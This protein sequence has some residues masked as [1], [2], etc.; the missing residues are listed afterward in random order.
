MVNESTDS[1]PTKE[2]FE[3]AR[4]YN[5]AYIEKL[6]DE[7]TDITMVGNESKHE[8]LKT[9][10]ETIQELQSD[11]KNIQEWE[12]AF[13]H[14]RQHIINVYTEADMTTGEVPHSLV[15]YKN[16]RVLVF[17]ELNCPAGQEGIATYILNKLFDNLKSNLSNRNV[18]AALPSSSKEKP[19]QRVYFK[20]IDRLYFIK[21]PELWILQSSDKIGAGNHLKMLPSTTTGIESF[22][23]IKSGISDTSIK[24][25]ICNI[26]KF[27]DFFPDLIP[28]TAL[29]YYSKNFDPTLS[30]KILTAQEHF[31]RFRTTMRYDIAE[32][33]MTPED[34]IAFICKINGLESIQEAGISTQE[35]LIRIKDLYESEI[36]KYTRNAETKKAWQDIEQLFV[37]KLQKSKMHLNENI[38]TFSRQEQSNLNALNASEHLTTIK[39]EDTLYTA[40][41]KNLN[42]LSGNTFTFM[43]EREKRQLGKG[44]LHDF[45]AELALKDAEKVAYNIQMVDLFF[46][47]MEDREKEVNVN[48]LSIYIKLLKTIKN[49]TTAILHNIED[50]EKVMGIIKE[51]KESRNKYS[52]QVE[53]IDN[54]HVYY[55]ISQRCS[56]IGFRIKYNAFSQ[57]TKYIIEH[58][59]KDNKRSHVLLATLEDINTSMKGEQNYMEKK[60]DNIDNIS[61]LEYKTKFFTKEELQDNK[62]IVCGKRDARLYNLCSFLKIKYLLGETQDANEGA[63]STFQTSNIKYNVE[64]GNAVFTSNAPIVP[65]GKR[66]KSSE[67]TSSISV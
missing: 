12:K 29:C 10:I 34:Q 1:M 21:N 53:Y 17:N 39:R 35:L 56:N 8:D 43:V 51:L 57:N 3:E 62:I 13:P 11:Y 67:N 26:E 64:E 27:N 60:T 22:D 63:V 55:Y 58:I 52:I 23:V 9:T 48:T 5:R 2:E 7:Y 19:Q 44:I 46:A 4:S 25:K 28:D 40:Y 14:L 6:Y 37:K 59:S 61:D 49:P 36:E 18:Y 50:A 15:P 47:R 65:A 45:T 66:F 24:V 33:R 32:E 16:E 20:D 30:M 31:E 38:S 41:I 42:C 54:N